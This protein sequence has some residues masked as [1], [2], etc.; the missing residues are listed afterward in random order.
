M[1]KNDRAKNTTTRLAGTPSLF[2]GD[3]HVAE[4]P[5]RLDVLRMRRILLDD[6]AQARDLHV[7]RAVED[8]VLAPGSELHQLVAR[9]RLPR[10]LDQH[11]EHREFAGGE[12]DR[13]AVL[14]ERA[15]REVELEA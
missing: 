3:E 10:V 7:D 14:G 4:A 8:L 1:S 6:L 12:R 2:D 13:L 11:L 5:D 15:R 9:E